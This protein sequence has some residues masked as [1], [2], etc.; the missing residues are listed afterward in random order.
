MKFGILGQWQ[1]IDESGDYK[2]EERYFI[3]QREVVRKGC[4]INK[5]SI[6]GN[7]EF[8]CSGFP[9]ADSW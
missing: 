4:Y 1:T 2:R 5:M 8:K 9:L 3:E 7:W 6:G